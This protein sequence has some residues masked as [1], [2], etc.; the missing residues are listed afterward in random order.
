MLCNG[1]ELLATSFSIRFVVMESTTSG[2]S[3]EATAYCIVC[4]KRVRYSE[5]QIHRLPSK[6]ELRELWVDTLRKNNVVSDTWIPKSGTRICGKHFLPTDYGAKDSNKWRKPSPNP[7]KKTGLSRNAIPSVFKSYIPR[8]TN[9]SSA[10]SR[11]LKNHQN[12]EKMPNIVDDEKLSFD[13]P[14]RL[15]TLKI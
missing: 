4:E 1:L 13:D 8:P 11:A 5:A 12:D 14:D 9:L 3:G 6:P 15:K 10:E 2:V 7:S